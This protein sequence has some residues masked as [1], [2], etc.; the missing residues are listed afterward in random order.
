MDTP[1]PIFELADRYVTGAA[2]LDPVWATEVGVVGVDD[3]MTDFSP[4]GVEARAAHARETLVELA[5][6]PRTGPHDELAAAFLTERL[7]TELAMI[8]ARRAAARPEQH[9]QPGAG[10]PRPAST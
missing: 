8:D 5:S 10:D 1:S 6:A 9:R 3:R 2:A 4:D 7:D